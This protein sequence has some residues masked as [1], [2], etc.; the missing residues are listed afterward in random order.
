MLIYWKSSRSAGLLFWG[1]TFLVEWF[2]G[3]LLIYVFW[4]LL[5]A[6]TSPVLQSDDKVVLAWNYIWADKSLRRGRVRCATERFDEIWGLI[7]SS[8]VTE[9]NAFSLST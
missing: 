6:G 1:L 4:R 9:H 5:V 2:G 7:P 8:P 3:L